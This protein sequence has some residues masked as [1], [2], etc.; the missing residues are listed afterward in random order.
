MTFLQII[1]VI[2]LGLGV[3]GVLA[4]NRDHGLWTSVLLVGM[5][6]AL[7]ATWGQG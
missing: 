3:P 7:W 5:A 2:G 4:T 1:A 6:S